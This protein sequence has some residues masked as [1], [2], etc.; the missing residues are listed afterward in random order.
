M[1]IRDILVTVDD[2]PVAAPRLRAAADLAR[3]FQAHLTG[4]FLASNVP[5]EFR[6]G[7][8]SYLMFTPELVAELMKT[9]GEALQVRSEAARLRFETAAGEAGAPSEWR[10]LTGDARAPLTAAARRSA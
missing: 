7:D 10:V 6:M 8:D 3:R 5:P 4:V 2:A 1:A 9:H